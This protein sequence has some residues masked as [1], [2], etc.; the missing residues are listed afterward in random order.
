[1]PTQPVRFDPNE[2]AIE[3]VRSWLQAGLDAYFNQDMGR[4]AFRPLEHYVEVRDD[5]A[6]DLCAIYQ[7]LTPYAQQR[8]R[9][10]IKDLLAM[11]GRDISKREGTRV[12]IDVAA[13]VRAHEVLDVLPALVANRT[14][15][16]LLDQ[17]VQTAV[18]LASQTD[19]SRACLER[20]Y[21]SPSFPSDYAGILLMALCHVDPDSWLSHVQNLA[22]PMDMLVRR[23]ADDSTA[24]RFYARNILD[25]ITLSRVRSANLALLSNAPESSWLWREWLVGHE[26]LLRCELDAESNNRLSLRGSSSP[27]LSTARSLGPTIAGVLIPGGRGKTWAAAYYEDRVAKLSHIR[28]DHAQ[29]WATGFLEDCVPALADSWKALLLPYLESPQPTGFAFC[30]I[31]GEP[32]AAKIDPPDYTESKNLDY[33]AARTILLESYGSQITPHHRLAA[34]RD[35]HATEAVTCACIL[36]QSPVS[37]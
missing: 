16:P 30:P 19:A 32:W 7:D 3:S 24:L 17:V 1:M 22:R 9:S 36:A 37:T 15:T 27:S 18:A 14:E 10:A 4:W 13:L 8:W 12:L 11:Q 20:I 21:T 35:R 6:E 33:K 28:I 31:R 25:A 34:L 29:E 2:A 26:S 23:L 5:L